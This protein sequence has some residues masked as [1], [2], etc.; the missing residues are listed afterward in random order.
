MLS[1]RTNIDEKKV[2]SAMDST[3]F[4]RFGKGE[5]ELTSRGI[6]GNKGAERVL[7]GIKGLYFLLFGPFGP[8][9]LF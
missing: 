1:K 3:F 4:I 8:F 2:L 7:K 9:G 6:K 5:M